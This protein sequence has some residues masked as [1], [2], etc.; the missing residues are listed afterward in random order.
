MGH[1][2]FD[3]P[4]LFMS[5]TR[6]GRNNDND[7]DSDGSNIINKLTIDYPSRVDMLQNISYFGMCVYIHTS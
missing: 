4:N 2:C 6:Y 1:P 5:A 7:K 3:V